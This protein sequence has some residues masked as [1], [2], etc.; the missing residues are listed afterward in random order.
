[1]PLSPKIYTWLC[2]LFASLGSIIFG[3]D[4]G[5]IAGVTPAPDFQRIM[6]SRWE[7]T[8]L[9]GLVVSI[10]VLGCFF[11]MIPVAYVADRFGRRHTIQLGALVYMLGGALQTGAH[12]MDMMLAGRFFAGFGVGIMSDL[13]PL[14]Q[15][16]I[17]HP[18]IRGRL[19]TLQQFMLG[20]GAFVAS[21]VTYGCSARLKGL[22]AEWRIPLGVQACIIIP[23]IPLFSFILLL[24]ESPRWLAENGRS[25]EAQATLARLHANND[26]TDPFVLAQMKDIDADIARSKDIGA[27]TWG[28]LFTERSNFR[29]VALGYILQFS[30]Q[31]TGVSAIQYYS[32]TIFKTMGFSSTRILL[33]QSINSVIALL[34]EAACVIWIDATGRRKPM[35]VGNIASGL[36]FV[37]GSILMARWPGTVN[38]TW[39]FNFFFSACIGP[40]SWAYP[41][42]IYSTRTRAKATAITSSGSWISNFFIAQVTS[43]AFNTIGWKYYLVFAIC[44]HTKYVID[45]GGFVQLMAIHPSALFIWA[46]YPETTG[47]RLEEMDALFQNA[48]L[49]IPGTPYTKVGDRLAAER[50]LRQGTF[51]PGDL[52]EHG[53]VEGDVDVE[54]GKESTEKIE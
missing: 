15:A 34:G 40:L 43:P 5:V 48:P 9:Q 8:N 32:T 16:E 31:M 37:V 49:F 3:Y 24:P 47:R 52:T 46:F 38:N 25:A 18:S 13:A 29:R 19:T 6:G 36:S 2:G 51:R 35:I 12:N 23:A 50:E 30:V 1:M 44:G 53:N 26:L 14:Y 21:W 54:A 22:P 10:F 42:E 17:A 39:V 27:A 20:I 7:N 33:F 41:A 4:L 28:E 11:G 45:L